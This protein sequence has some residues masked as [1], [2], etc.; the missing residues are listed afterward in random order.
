MYI[1][2]DI[3]VT[4]ARFPK[5]RRP[6]EPERDVARPVPNF[7]LLAAALEQTGWDD[8][9]VDETSWKTVVA[10]FIGKLDWQAVVRDVDPFLED[11][12]DRRLLERDLLLGELRR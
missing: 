5:P 2:Y 12:R 3:L 7:E 6:S 10:G 1:I 4:L 8:A 11:S 9:R